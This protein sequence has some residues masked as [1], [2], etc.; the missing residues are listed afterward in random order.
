MQKLSTKY[1]QTKFKNPL[2]MSEKGE[3]IMQYKLVVTE[4]T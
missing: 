4:E 2:G 1:N 3:G